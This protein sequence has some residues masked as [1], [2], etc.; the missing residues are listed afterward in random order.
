MFAARPAATGR[1]RNEVSGAPFVSHRLITRAHCNKA[2][3]PR[4]IRKV[5]TLRAEAQ[6]RAAGH[7]EGR[8]SSRPGATRRG[9]A[10]GNHPARITRRDASRAAS[11]ARRPPSAS[12]RRPS[13]VSAKLR[14]PPRTFARAPV[15]FSPYKTSLPAPPQR[16]PRR[17]GDVNRQNRR[18]FSDTRAFQRAAEASIRRLKLRARPPNPFQARRNLRT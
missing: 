17:A 13:A 15:E 6:G 5:I 7:G 10:L 12:L 8:V 1:C 2:S 3:A 14:S 4:D 11:A 16:P 18:G 9:A